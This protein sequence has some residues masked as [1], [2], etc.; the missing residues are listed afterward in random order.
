MATS[1]LYLAALDSLLNG[2]IDYL[3]ATVKAMLVDG[4]Y[5]P[6][7]THRY[8]ADV[9]GEI[10]GTGYT[11]G[12]VTLTGKTITTAGTR[13]LRADNPSWTGT[14]TFRW[15]IFYVDTG[16][17]ATSP[18]LTSV[19]FES[20]QSVTAETFTYLIPSSGFLRIAG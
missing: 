12:G 19:D 6:A 20:D 3:D 10:T 4:T 11:T 8:A 17:P 16:T 5:T 9:T 1:T 2:E 7:P 13:E 14:F 15:L 18:L